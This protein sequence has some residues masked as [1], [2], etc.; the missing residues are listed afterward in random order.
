MNDIQQMITLRKYGF[1]ILIVYLT[2]FLLAL[3]F[4]RMLLIPLTL[5]LTFLLLVMGNKEYRIMR[6]LTVHARAIKW[7]RIQ[8]VTTW[9]E[10]LLLSIVMT[11][12]VFDYTIGFIT[13]MIF[14]VI[15]STNSIRS[16]FI[17]NKLKAVEPNLPTFDQLIE[18]MS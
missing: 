5:L 3:F 18:R 6:R 4:E 17:T 12:L 11:T 8:Y 14:A 13:G 10:A 15:Q 7:L 2:F 1:T 16:R 9:L